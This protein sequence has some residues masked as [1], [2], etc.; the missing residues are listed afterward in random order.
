M[1]HVR[2]FDLSTDGRNVEGLAYLYDRASLVTDDGRNR[3]LEEMARGTETKTLRERAQRPLFRT[4]RRNEDPIGVSTF[5]PSAEGLIFR[6][7]ISATRAGDETL[8]LVNDGA[9]N[10]ASVGFLAIRT[11]KRPTADGLVHVRAEIAIR[12]LS[13]CPTGL[14]QHQGAEVLAVRAEPNGT[15]RLDASRRRLLLL[16]LNTQGH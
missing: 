9:M 12:E 16:T 2:S 13:L 3:Y 8:E 6:A 1:I 7:R 11:L 5:E 10:S 14:G 15:P 4:H